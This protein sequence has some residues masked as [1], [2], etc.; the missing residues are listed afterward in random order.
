MRTRPVTIPFGQFFEVPQCIQRIDVR[1]TH[2]WQVRYGGTKFFSDGTPD[3]SGAA[4][5]LK[6]ATKEL[7]ARIASV[8][9]A[10]PIHQ[11]PNRRKT[12]DLPAGISGPI[13]RRRAGTGT[14]IAEFSLTLPQFGKQAKRRTVYI[15][16]E[17]TYSIARFKLA[18]A[19]A[20]EL[21][22]A[23]VEKYEADA[24]RARRQAASQLRAKL[25][26]DAA[27]AKA[28]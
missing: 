17:R 23:A 3:G 4:A 25:R 20:I 13:V 26:S 7:L 14:R 22:T 9:V 5:S 15:G 21:R 27:A 16:T 11:Q 28:Q 10:V 24:T 8:P 2:G 18:L 12:N 19:K 1:S 6:R